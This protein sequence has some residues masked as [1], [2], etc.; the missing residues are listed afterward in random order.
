MSEQILD[1]PAVSVNSRS[2]EID[3]KTRAIEAYIGASVEAVL[4]G[5]VDSPQDGLL[6]LSSWHEAMPAMVFLDP[7]LEPVDKVVF[8]VLWIWGR[9]HGRSSMAFPCYEYLM[10]RCGIQ[11]RSTLSRCLA[12][13]RITR[14]VTLCRKV[15]DARGRNRGNIYALHEEPL[16]LGGT[17]HLDPEYMRVLTDAAQGH[18]HGRVRRVARAM[19]DSIRDQM[20]DGEDVLDDSL[21]TQTDRRLQATTFVLRSAAKTTDEESPAYFGFRTTRLKALN[22][23]LRRNEDP[24]EAGPTDSVRYSNSVPSHRVRISNSVRSSSY[25]YKKTTTTNSDKELVKGGELSTAPNGPTLVYP[26]SLSQNEC[27][28]AA[29]KVAEMSEDLRQPLLDELDGQIRTRKN[30]TNPIRNN[31]R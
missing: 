2:P 26:E 9:Q 13:L 28:L 31:L 29:I 22:P 24:S 21:M 18:H 20:A 1:H 12:I 5:G 14:W 15:R 10:E 30:S 7:V 25:I 8:A 23:A 3:P 6:F 11:S 27:A 17:V 4:R 16:A 19:L